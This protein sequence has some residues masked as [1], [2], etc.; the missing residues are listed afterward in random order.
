MGQE[1][2]GTGGRSCSSFILRQH[3]EICPIYQGKS[4]CGSVAETPGV[5]SSQAGT[6]RCRPWVRDRRAKRAARTLLRLIWERKL[7]SICGNRLT[8]SQWNEC[9][10]GRDRPDRGRRVLDASSTGS[11]SPVD[12][13]GTRPTN[14]TGGKIGAPAT[15]SQPDHHVFRRGRL[16]YKAKATWE[17][18][19]TAACVRVLALPRPSLP[20][21]AGSP[22]CSTD[23]FTTNSRKLTEEPNTMRLSL[24][25]SRSDRLKRASKIGSLSRRPRET[26]MQGVWK[27]R[28]EESCQFEAAWMIGNDRAM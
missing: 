18:N 25:S 15:A 7:C 21:P 1:R 19:N 23:L 9:S 17:R 13:D 26:A 20:W 12:W 11:S 2:G 3:V 10:D 28:I 5:V 8:T 22:A 4:L 16:C 14:K 27:I 6:G 24:A